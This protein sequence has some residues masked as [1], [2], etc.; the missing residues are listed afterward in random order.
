[1]NTNTNTAQVAISKVDQL[2]FLNEQI[3][4]LTEQAEIIKNELKA[5]A[6]LSG[7]KAFV[8]S[9]FVATYTESNRGTFDHKKLV[10]DLNLNEDQVKAYTKVCAV[11]TIKVNQL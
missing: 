2:G 5:E 10:S 9:M 3:K 7:V 4:Q 6:S 1:M 8:G 11:Y